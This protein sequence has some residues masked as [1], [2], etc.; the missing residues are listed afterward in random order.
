MGGGVMTKVPSFQFDDVEI[1]L[2]TNPP[3]IYDESPADGETGVLVGSNISF[4]TEDPDADLDLTTLNVSFVDDLGNSVDMV[5]AGVAQ[6]GYALATSPITNGFLVT[7]NPDDDFA[8]YTIHTVTA[9]I[10]DLQPVSTEK[11]W[12]F[13]T[14]DGPIG[15]ALSASALANYIKLSWVVPDGMRVTNYQ[16]VKHPDHYPL[17][18][19]DGEIIYDGTDTQFADFDV[20]VDV[21]YFYT[22][23]VLRRPGSYLE[24]DTDASASATIRDLAVPAV[25][26]AEYVPGRGEFGHKTKNPV[27]RGTTIEVWG[28][29]GRSSDLIDT[30]PATLVVCPATGTVRS[31][32]NSARGSANVIDIELKSGLVMRL[33]GVLLSSR[34]RRNLGLV[35]GEVIGSTTGADIEFTIYKLPTETAGQRTVRPLYFYLVVERRENR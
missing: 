1:A 24:Y 22:I 12:E 11:T 34:I 4:K 31:I 32:S 3:L 16:L 28:D 25:T 29:N 26:G 18:L 6:T 19:D 35:A 17:T 13:D 20:E 9:G 33:D 2:L 21:E 14:E 15:V 10:S 30:K 8:A 7:I 5:L 23:F 27:P